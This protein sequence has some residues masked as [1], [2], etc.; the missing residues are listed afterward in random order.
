MLD[1]AAR[2]EPL[3]KAA[4][5]QGMHALGITDH[6]NM[7]GAYEFYSQARKHG[8]KPII[9]IEA[10]LT[11]GTHRSERK[12]VQFGD[13]TGDDVAAKGAYTHMTMWAEN[14]LG[15]HNLFRLSSRS[16]LEGFFYKPRADRELLNEYHEGVIATTGCPSGEVQ[17]YL[18]LGRYD[19]AVRSAAEFQSIFGKDNFYVELMDHGLEI[20]T[21]IRGDLL[22]LAKEIGAPLVATNDLHYVHAED[23]EAHDTLL[24]VS[25]GSNK[26]TPGRFKFDGSGYY[27]KTV[28]EMRRL[29]ANLS[30]AC[31]NTLAIAERCDVH[32]EEAT[33]TFMPQFDVPAGHTET[34]WFIAE[35]DRG[36]MRRF[37]EGVTNEVLERAKYEEDVIIQKG[38]PGYF[39]VVA[40]YIN[41]AKQNGVQVGPGRGSGAGSMCAYA[42][43]ITELNPLTHKLLFERFLNPERPSMPDFDVDFD[44]RRRG[45]VIKYVTEKYGSEHVSQIV[46]YGTI[47]AKQAIKDAGRVLGKPYAVGERITKAFTPPSQGTDVTI[48]QVFD[49]AHERYGE[50]ADF[51]TMY[52][53]DPEVKEVVE[54]ARGIENLKRQWGVHAAGVI[55]SSATITD[56]I[57]VMRRE[58]DGQIITQFDYPSCEALGLVKMDFLGLRNLTILG[59]AVALVESNQGT[60]LDLISLA[61]D[62]TD[63][64]TYALLGSGDTLGVFQFDGPGYQQL[65]RQMQPD[66]FSDITALGALYRPGPMGTN[67]HTNYALR[68]NGQQAVTYVHSEL[69]AALEPILGETYGLLVYQEQVMEIARLLAG[70]TLGAADLLRK[71]MGK[72][73]I[74]VLEAEFGTFKAG[75][76][77]NGFS[78]KSI[79]ALWDTM[80][81]FSAYGFNKSH[82]AAYG[83]ISYWTAYLKA[84]YPV[85]Y[86]AALLQST[87]DNKD[88]LAIYL[89]E[90]RRMGIQVL[91]PD[92]N[93]SDSAFTPVGGDI[94]FG[95]GAIR[96]IG[97][98]VVAGIVK[99]R[100]ENGPAQDF[101]E[102]LE[103]SPLVVCN[104]RSVDS[105]IKAGA[106]DS[107]GHKRRALSEIF[108][109]A[110]DQVT[111]LKR[112]AEHGQ[113]SLLGFF[114][115]AEVKTVEHRPLPDLEEWDRRIKLA[116]EREMLGLYVSDHPLNGLEHI[117]HSERTIGIANLL[118]EPV[119][120]THVL[121][122][123]IT[124][125]QRKQTKKGDLWAIC[126]VEDL[127]AS[128]Q[129]MVYPKT[130]APV[131]TQ[132]ATDVIVKIKGRASE[133]DEGVEFSAQE[134][135][136]PAITDSGQSGPITV[137]LAADR[138]TPAVVDR[139][140]EVLGNHPGIS[141][142]Q[143]KLTS[144]GSWQLLRLADEYRVKVTPALL[145]DLKALLGPAAVTQ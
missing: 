142:V 60:K 119:V 33:G 51:R 137:Q 128:I 54:T 34:S 124:G 91:P 32:F 70:Y 120:G 110:I 92:V 111:D 59:D 39:L 141:E 127:D 31:D 9:G 79:Q 55:M 30:I 20:E 90:C 37:P 64:A 19:E 41:W 12:R 88:R 23:A 63:P 35:V 17:T 93:S 135:S 24:C 87:K 62:P 44:D 76:Q 65:C 132:L 53:T 94:R 96:N 68:K 29:F 85:E 115:E 126:S 83:V 2:V 15:M 38:Y 57:P 43:G 3:V 58:A 27:L 136:F 49:P 107:L 82:A 18:R 16:S 71:A 121:A 145:A 74:E 113:D 130:Y 108:E 4:K 116:F 66:S 138:C 103:H 140:K 72:K 99:G 11:P 106:F 118:A 7:F 102:F 86:M 73:K 100:D 52:E 56:V 78:D 80:V 109:A 1:G 26:D 67:T 139:L 97:E 28:H 129:V 42:L 47:K 123:M 89:S 50:G 144:P 117:L 14:S 77:A 21:R 143:L 131:A 13:G 101:Y 48:D 8:V 104:K 36:L 81:P 133:R 6:G 46:T 114:E 98:N 22:K 105:L 45:D 25:S 40:D 75:M 61:N 69:A 125:I 134:I 112:N 95:L 122:G 5:D 10:Y 84:N